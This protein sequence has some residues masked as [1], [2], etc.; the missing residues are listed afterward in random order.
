M[1]RFRLSAAYLYSQAA[2]TAFGV[3]TVTEITFL[4]V[5]ITFRPWMLGYMVFTKDA[6]LRSWESCPASGSTDFG[7]VPQGLLLV[8]FSNLASSVSSFT[9][10]TWPKPQA[11]S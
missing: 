6:K 7:E 9:G 2:W 5:E 4:R 11:S 8:T 10:K 3:P 1:S